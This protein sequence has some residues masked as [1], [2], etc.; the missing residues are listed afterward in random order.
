MTDANGLE[1]G[2]ER[3]GSGSLAQGGKFGHIGIAAWF[4]CVCGWLACAGMCL[5]LTIALEAYPYAYDMFF[6]AVL[7]ILF[8]NILVYLFIATR[9]ALD[10]RRLA[11]SVLRVCA[12][13]GLILAGMFAMGKYC[14]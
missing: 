5:W 3:A 12:G 8:C 6:P 13:E 2:A 1:G 9:W 10:L 4:I 11:G 7:L 14:M